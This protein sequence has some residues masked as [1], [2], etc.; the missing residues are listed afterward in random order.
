MAPSTI[1]GAGIGIF[2][3]IERNEGD[4]VGDGDIL[5]PIADV[6]WHLQASQ[7]YKNYDAA[8]RTLDPTTD[9]VWCKY[10]DSWL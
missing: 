5:L 7:D 10:R 9:Y 8:P 6:W 1:Q 4:L 3:G 2:T